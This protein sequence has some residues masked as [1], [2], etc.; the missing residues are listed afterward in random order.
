[1]CSR[2]QFW[3]ENPSVIAQ[4]T[5]IIPDTR[6]S[7]E[8]QLNA[9]TRFVLLL[10]VLLWSIKYKY[11]LYFLL[12][13][14]LLIICLYY[15][16]INSMK[17]NF[18]SLPL[19]NWK[20]IPPLDE[21]KIEN[22]SRYRFC[23]DDRGI[24]SNNSYYSTNQALAA[25]P[26]KRVGNPKIYR[27]P[28]VVPRANATDYWSEDFIVPSGIND[29]TQQELFL[30][31]AI[32]PSNCTQNYNFSI[33]NHPVDYRSPP[34]PKHTIPDTRKEV[35]E[36]FAYSGSLD[37]DPKFTQQPRNGDVG[38]CTY[39][40]EHL[41]HNIPT[42]VP[43]GRCALDDSYNEYN[44]N[45]YTNYLGPNTFVQNQ[46]TDS[47]QSNIG[48]DYAQQ[49]HPVRCTKQGNDRV[50]VTEDPRL[51]KP[52]EPYRRAPEATPSNV[53]DP[54]SFGYGTEYRHYIDPMSGQSRFYY[55]DIDAI[56]RPNFII[57]SNV[58]HA[59][60]ASSYGPMT[61]KT[62][63]S[64]ELNR[65]LAN[66]QYLE[67]TLGLREELQERYM[68]S[69]NAKRGYQLR[70]APIHRMGASMSMKTKV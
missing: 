36:P 39:N 51:A 53:Y 68:R 31:G 40:P 33:E 30:S 9:A 13:S 14:L 20:S 17:E 10:W 66:R 46:V 5:E 58:D 50:F 37:T 1:M 45:L 63:P 47:L 61:E 52:V 62:N 32:G 18:E 48:I 70:E 35:I 7:L 65:S 64:N 29:E 23:Q 2:Q 43:V 21:L 60:W 59:A 54:R 25:R 41:Q 55:D 67:G 16:Q 12:F 15:V 19:Q 34:Y 11:H 6:D 44:R 49:F 69:Y 28:L 3:L 22:P 27:T 8:E 56:R 38:G 4:S 42:N 57:R 26:G 24:P